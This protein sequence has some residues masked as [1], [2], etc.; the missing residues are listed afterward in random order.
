ME[1]ELDRHAATF[2]FRHGGYSAQMSIW[3]RRTGPVPGVG[4]TL[5]DDVFSAKVGS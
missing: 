5:T 4:L 3:T 1:A 2:D